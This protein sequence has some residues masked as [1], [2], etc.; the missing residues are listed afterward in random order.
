[1]FPVF[2]ASLPH[3]NR[4]MKS[5]RGITSPMKN[6]IEVAVPFKLLSHFLVYSSR[7]RR[8]DVWQW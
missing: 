4:K 6:T 8:V 5:K 1:M 2:P 3:E 7:K